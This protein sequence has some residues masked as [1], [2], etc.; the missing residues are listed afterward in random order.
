M[1][2]HNLIKVVGSTVAHVFHSLSMV[3]LR[4]TL[5]DTNASRPH[6]VHLHT[7]YRKNGGVC[8]RG[9]CFE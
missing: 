9:V 4:K 6:T 5:Y 3:P 1:N 8:R 2:P 7:L